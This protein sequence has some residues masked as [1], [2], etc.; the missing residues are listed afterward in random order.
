M[1]YGRY[2]RLN[3][4]LSK[5]V[6]GVA[7]YDYIDLPAYFGPSVDNPMSPKYPISVTITSDSICF[8]LHY[9]A[10][11]IE[12]KEDEKTD[13]INEQ[14][15]SHYA[16][17]KEDI[18]DKAF[19]IEDERISNIMG[20]AHM[21]EVILELPYTDNVSNKLLDTIKKI[22]NTKF[23]LQEKEKDDEEQISYGGR[24]IEQLIRK[25]YPGYIRPEEEV[26]KLSLEDKMYHMLQVVSDNT[27]SYSSLWL[28][29]L[30][31]LQTNAIYL[32]DNK[33]HVVGFLRKLLLDF[34]FDLK[35]SDVFQNS[36]NYQKMYS[37]L[38]SNFYFSA[39]MHKCDY[40]YHRKLIRK[41]INQE[42]GY[43]R[44]TIVT[45]YAE[46][47]FR[48]EELWAK[49]IMS[50]DAEERFYYKDISSWQEFKED[51]VFKKYPSWFADPEEEMRRICFTM[52]EKEGKQERHMCNMDILVRLLNIHRDSEIRNQIEPNMVKM[53]DD[54]FEQISKWFLKRYDFKD[55]FHLHM[56]KY[57][58]IMI[59]TILVILIFL[60]MPLV[61]LDLPLIIIAGSTMLCLMSLMRLLTVGQINSTSKNLIDKRRNIM[62]L[63]RIKSYSAVAGA[64]TLFFSLCFYWDYFK[65][66]FNNS[67]ICLII[68]VIA[69]VIAPLIAITPWDKLK[70]ELVPIEPKLQHV[71]SNI[72]LLLPRLVA[73]ITASWITLSVGFDL[74]VAFFDAT[75][76]WSTVIV[77]M[78]I[79][80]LFVMFE[81]N[82]VAPHINAKVKLLRS[83]ELIVFSYSISL[84]VGLFI[85]NFLGEKFLEKG[86][87]VGEGEFYKQYVKR[88]D[89]ERFYIT[90]DTICLLG[91]DIDSSLFHNNVKN[92]KNVY[93]GEIVDTVIENRIKKININYTYALVEDISIFGTKH[94]FVLRDFLIMF[95]FIAM[96]M[97]IFIQLIILG[98]NKQMTEL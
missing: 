28:M 66:A 6:D 97:G 61:A 45:L 57:A 71:M 49:D 52:R 37:G 9:S 62:S 2:F 96:F 88:G 39:L 81:I 17:S 41:A 74:Y 91:K 89:K 44:D 46:E 59:I 23:P 47:L 21:E 32:Y 8:K 30:K 35:H 5:V 83:V 64:L 27:A 60:L 50:T 93:H 22:Y 55:L 70:S 80:L 14:E 67:H 92:L 86:G 1:N 78:V 63:C 84:I 11:K 3:Q 10:F 90:N 54:T 31:E 19:P 13:N 75:P 82:K 87:Y 34:M 73:S 18:D 65:K 68:I 20:M 76:D 12:K 4:A 77:L 36:A 85:V 48:A 94:I 7:I 26:E 98:D 53:R 95:S 24:F 16:Y 15:T 40:Y 38:M 29:D 58:N 25:R 69:L 79:L 42:G 56:Y 72:H 43:N 51:C 33:N